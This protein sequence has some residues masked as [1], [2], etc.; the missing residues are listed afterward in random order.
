V[1][2]DSYRVGLVGLDLDLSLSPVLHE[3]EGQALGLD[4][5][6]DVF[7]GNRNPD[8]NDLNSVLSATHADGYRGVNVTHPYK[9]AVIE[10]V[11]EVSDDAWVLGAVNTV[12]FEESRKVGHNT[13]WH[14][15]AQSIAT[16]LNDVPRSVV[17]QFGA[18]GAGVAV[19]HAL[20]RSG[21]ERLVLLDVDEGRAGRVAES[22]NTAHSRT[23]IE[24]GTVADA[25]KWVP[26]ADGVVNATPIGMPAHP[27]SAVPLALLR[28]DL[29]VHDV[30]YMPL[31]TELMAAARRV[32]ALTVGGGSMLVHQA[33][34]GFRL[35]TGI[36]PDVARMVAHL[37]R[38]V[39]E[40]GQVPARRN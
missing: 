27:G 37:E 1:S 12:V 22:L 24:V 23:A 8:Y 10:L 32:G 7:D 13:D 17:V 2:K 35:F 5:S 33:A 38:I 20:L 6:Y 25:A 18:G 11:D 34:E 36:A 40:G 4:Y 3:T 30:V 39:A 28:P 15:F 29:W 19:A 21:V 26:S 9:Q 14:G 31:E 16:N